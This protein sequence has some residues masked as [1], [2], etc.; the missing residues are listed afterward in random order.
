MYEICCRA[1]SC[2]SQL[3]LNVTIT[4]VIMEQYLYWIDVQYNP[5]NVSSCHNILPIQ[6]RSKYLSVICRCRMCL[7]FTPVH[8][9]HAVSHTD[10]KG[11]LFTE[12]GTSWSDIDGWQ[13]VR[14]QLLSQYLLDIKPFV[15]WVIYN[16]KLD[17]A[18]GVPDHADSSERCE[19][20]PHLVSADKMQLT[21]ELCGFCIIAGCDLCALGDVWGLGVNKKH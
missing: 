9:F 1:V 20:S 10:A 15:L 5:P 6:T 16:L 21:A 2:E 17:N 12:R 14:Q 4:A 7:E 18:I 3:L 11:S 8:F 13:R 19:I